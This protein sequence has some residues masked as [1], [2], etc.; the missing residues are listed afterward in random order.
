MEA[1]VWFQCGSPGD[2]DLLC[3]IFAS[4][5]SKATF[6]TLKASR[7]T[8]TSAK[9]LRTTS[10]LH[11]PAAVEVLA[12]CGRKC[13]CAP[14]M[15]SC[16]K[17]ADGSAA[18]AGL[19]MA[20]VSQGHL[21]TSKCFHQMFSDYALEISVQFPCL[22]CCLSLVVASEKSQHKG[23]LTGPLTFSFHFILH[24]S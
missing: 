24:E 1:K 4:H 9:L 12:A 23:R 7:C 18:S 20:S 3:D 17:R 5:S 8:P 13:F 6:K 10:R 19:W 22:A 16:S 15:F 11:Q 14:R 2:H 21:I